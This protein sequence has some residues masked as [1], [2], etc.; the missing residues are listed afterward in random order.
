MSLVY[1]LLV[2]VLLLYLKWILIVLLFPFQMVQA[3]MKK[4]SQIWKV[5]LF[6]GFSLFAV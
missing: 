4:A 5:F 3:Y 1:I 6:D 2:L